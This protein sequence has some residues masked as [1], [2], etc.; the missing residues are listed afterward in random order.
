MGARVVS[1]QEAPR[2]HGLIERLCIQA[3]L[4]KPRVA[5]AQ[6]PMPNAFAIGRSPKNATVCATTGILDLRSA[7]WCRPMLDALASPEHRELAWRQL[8][9]LIDQSEPVGPLSASLALECGLAEGRP[10]VISQG[11][12]FHLPRNGQWASGEKSSVRPLTAGDVLILQGEPAALEQVVARAG[13]ELGDAA[14]GKAGPG[15]EVGVM[16]AV[17]TADSP[18]LGR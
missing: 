4:P 10:R 15:E 9:R 12:R 6:T 5:I 18:L 2:L 3:N 8:P 1:P 14:S 7:T 17:V 11:R 13:L 16:E